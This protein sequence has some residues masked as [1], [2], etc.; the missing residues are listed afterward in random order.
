MRKAGNNCAVLLETK[1]R[2]FARYCT[3]IYDFL[4][5]L[6]HFYCSNTAC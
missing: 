2:F 4:I 3:V 6:L 5:Q 1:K